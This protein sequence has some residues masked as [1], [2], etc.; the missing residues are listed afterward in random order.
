[1]VIKAAD[2]DILVLMAYACAKKN[3]E[4]DWLMQIEIDTYVSVK[5]IISY[6][7]DEFCSVLPAYHSITGCD[8]RSRQYW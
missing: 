1:M 7:G 3:I 5:S 8:T 2:T 6:Y 4:Q